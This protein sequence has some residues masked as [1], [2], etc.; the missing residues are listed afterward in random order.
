MK[1]SFFTFLLVLTNFLSFAQ[2]EERIRFTSITS[3]EETGQDYSP[4]LDD[5]LQHLIPSSWLPA[6]LKY[7]EVTLKLEKRSKI[8]RL[9]F[10]DHEGVFTTNPAEIY[11][12]NGTQKIF[13]GLFKGEAYLSFVDLILK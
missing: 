5:N 3:A 8:K 10:Y 7:V 13:L 1:I 2:L 11:A 6:N 4:W 12:L 9:S